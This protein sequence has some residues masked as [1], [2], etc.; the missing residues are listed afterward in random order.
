MEPPVEWS[1]GILQKTLLAI[2]SHCHL[3][4]ALLFSIPVA[5][6]VAI[7]RRTP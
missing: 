1:D 4:Y 7:R 6:V 2:P 5:L 3:V